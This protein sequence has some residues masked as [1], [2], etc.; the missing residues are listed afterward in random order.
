MHRSWKEETFRTIFF[1][2][3]LDNDL[4]VWED[5]SRRDNPFVVSSSSFPPENCPFERESESS[6]RGK[7][8]V[9]N[10]IIRGYFFNEPRE[11]KKE[12][13]EGRKREKTVRSGS[14]LI[15]LR[16]EVETSETGRVKF[17]FWPKPDI[18]APQYSFPRVSFIPLVSSEKKTV[19]IVVVV[20]V[21]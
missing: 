8:R 11:R 3:F 9:R 12:R 19:A 18:S 7:Y 2:F 20:V 21:G 14:R 1:F 16:G 15:R 17:K 5:G 13:K 6:M 10:D 4:K